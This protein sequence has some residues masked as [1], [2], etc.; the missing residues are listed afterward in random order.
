M[1]FNYDVATDA[2]KVRLLCQDVIQATAWFQ[3]ADIQAMLD[4]NLGSVRLA[5]AQ[6]CDGIAARLA[7]SSNKT[8]IGDYQIDTSEVYKAFLSLAERLRE[9]EYNLPAFGTVEE[10]LSGF[11]ELMII[12]NWVLRTQI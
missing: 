3:D 7:P 9:D 12:R 2:G 4:L 5:A 8:V 6:A 11:N 1:A 10:P